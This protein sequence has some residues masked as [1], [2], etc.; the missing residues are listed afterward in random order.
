[1]RWPRFACQTASDSAADTCS[2][3]LRTSSDA[4]AM[5]ADRLRGVSC[6]YT[7]HPY[8]YCRSRT[9]RY[10]SGYRTRFVRLVLLYTKSTRHSRLELLFR[11]HQQSLEKHSPGHLSR[12]ASIHSLHAALRHLPGTGTRVMSFCVLSQ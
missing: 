1:M 6:S 7:L 12:H 10:A 9:Q 8:S 5:A 3:P 4:S 2:T 11:R